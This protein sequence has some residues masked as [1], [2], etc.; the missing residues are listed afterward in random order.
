MNLKKPTLAERT[1]RLTEQ[2]NK[3]IILL[4]YYITMLIL[5]PASRGLYTSKFIKELTKPLRT[6]QRHT[7]NQKTKDAEVIDV[8]G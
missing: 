1:Q 8:T 7:K 4:S 5:L 6:Q 3:I 2:A